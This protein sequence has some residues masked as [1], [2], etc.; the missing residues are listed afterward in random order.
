MLVCPH[1]TEPEH[2]ERERGAVIQSRFSSQTE[3]DRFGIVLVLDLHVRRKDGI[4][5][6]E[7]RAQQHGRPSGSP[8]A[9][10]ANAAIPPMVSSIATVASRIAARQRRS[11]AGNRSFK[12]AVNS[13]MM[14]AISVS[15]SRAEASS[16]APHAEDRRPTAPERAGR[17]IE[18]RRRQRQALERGAGE[19]HADEQD[20]GDDEPSREHQVAEPDGGAE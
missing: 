17:E 2:D 9:T 6:R 19:R 1:E 18:H 13:E 12:P 11:D 7:Q 4:G 20:A 3:A 16:T 15:R 14:T 5:R 10:T 8:R